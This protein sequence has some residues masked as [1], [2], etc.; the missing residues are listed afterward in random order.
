MTDVPIDPDGI[1]FL[2]AKLGVR[3][4]IEDGD[5]VLDLHPRPEILHHGMIRTSVLA[6]VIDA[7]AGLN[8]DGDPDSWA[9]TTDLSIRARPTPA[10]DLVVARHRILRQGTRSVTCEVELTDAD[11]DHLASGS[12]GFARVR[13]K[14]S[15]PPKFVVTPDMAPGLFADLPFLAQP[16]RA[17]AGVDVVDG[18]LGIVEMPVRPDVMNPAGTLQGGMVALLVESAAEEAVAAATGAP[19]VVVD[20]DIRFLAAARVGPVRSQ[21]RMVGPSPHDGVEVRLHDRSS[22]ALTTLAYARAVGV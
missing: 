8:V 21:C 9:F 18:A 3:A 20:L 13:R 10:T 7:I 14:D 6:Y 1:N 11:G 2:P 19:T 15:D 16:L 12:I 4:R 17:A 5:L 22:G